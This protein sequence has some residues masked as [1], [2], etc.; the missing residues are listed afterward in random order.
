MQSVGPQP[1]DASKEGS[2][3]AVRTICRWFYQCQLGLV[4]GEKLFSCLEYG[5]L[6]LTLIFFA[7]VSQRLKEVVEGSVFRS[8]TKVALPEEAFRARL[9][10]LRKKPG[11]SKEDVPQRLKPHYKC[12][13]YGTAKAVPLSKAKT[14]SAALPEA[15]CP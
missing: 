10:R 7:M 15:A 9:N 4:P 3:V 12:G 5:K 2:S 14:F 8:R 11:R 13:I 1:F 6:P